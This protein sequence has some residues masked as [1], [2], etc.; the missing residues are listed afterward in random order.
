MASKGGRPVD[1]IWQFYV[2]VSTDGKV[3]K[4]KCTECETMVSAK[5]ERLR[6]RLRKVVS[7]DNSSLK[8][9]LSSVIPLTSRYNWL[10]SE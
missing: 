4:A 5:V 8:H 7:L 6:L 2:R 9:C 10:L 1:P 3:P